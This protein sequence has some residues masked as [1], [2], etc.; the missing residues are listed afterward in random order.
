MFGLIYADP[1]WRYES[2]TARPWDAIEE[3][4]PTISLEEIQALGQKIQKLAAPDCVLYL[5]VPAPKVY[6]ACSVIDAWGFS[7]RTNGV[8]VKDRL[9]LG[10]WF[11]QRH[12]LLFVAVRGHPIP[13]A[14][15]DRP[16]SVIESPRRQHSQK[17]VELADMLDRIY[18]DVPKVELFAREERPAWTAWGNEVRPR[19]T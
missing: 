12:E 11:R 17:P 4:Y 10:Y 3:H 6:E 19:E 14:D 7:Y 1:P 9:G 8:W 2:G 16:D 13:P 5:W 18:P 15:R